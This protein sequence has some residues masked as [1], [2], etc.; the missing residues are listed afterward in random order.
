MNEKTLKVLEYYKI[1]DKL[2]EK[3]ESSL[4][5]EIANNLKPI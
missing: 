3:T 1:I 4:G 2:K 5:R